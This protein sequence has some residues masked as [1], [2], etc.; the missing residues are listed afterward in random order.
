M[1]IKESPLSRTKTRTKKLVILISLMLVFLM[2]SGYVLFEVSKS[3]SFQFF[4]GLIGKVETTEKV[5]ALTFDDGP[6]PYTEEIL[7]ILQEA[8][9]KATFFLTGLEIEQ[10]RE[11]AEAI[12]QAGHEI[13]NHSYSHQRMV[14][15]SPA[16]IKE[17]IEKTDELIREVGYEGEIHFRPPYGKRLLLLPYYLKQTERKTILWN[18]EPETYPEIAVD[19]GKIVDHVVEN[20]EPGSIILLHVMYESRKPSLD[21][22]REI[23]RKLEEPGYTFVTVS[24]LLEF[25]K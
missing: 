22:V 15:K 1:I 8:N 6:G 5:V 20:I 3:R 7:H 2:G 14:L 11:A 17:E 18:I 4:G 13:G 24:E 25:E 19:S 23:I 21:S 10:N 16:F 12:V 9:T